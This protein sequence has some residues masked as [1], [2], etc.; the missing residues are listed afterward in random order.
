MEKKKI[1]YI[2]I[3][4]IISI[5]ICW[6]IYPKNDYTPYNYFLDNQYKLYQ[7]ATY[8]DEH[9]LDWYIYYDSD[10]VR[11]EWTIWDCLENWCD[12][13][14][15]SKNISML[16]LEL[17]KWVGYSYDNFLNFSLNEEVYMW[18]DVFSPEEASF[19]YKK[20]YFKD[21]DIG[22][23]KKEP[24]DKSGIIYIFNDDWW[25]ITWCYQCYWWGW[26]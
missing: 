14:K 24:W 22:Y 21:I 1:N 6:I 3:F 10:N 8:I 25:V 20:W 17:G 13:L 26:D 2:I 15:D 12:N 9:N 19:V 16:L 11:K 23:N 4:I 5:I 18:K 7:I